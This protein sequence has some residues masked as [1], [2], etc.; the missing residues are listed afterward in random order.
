MCLASVKRLGLSEI[1]EIFVV[2]EDLH[3]ERGAMEVVP[4]RLQGTND[5]EKFAVIDI[6]IP[7]SG[8]EGL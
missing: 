8:G 1:G 4:P 2:G 3:R 7:F 6:V 5:S